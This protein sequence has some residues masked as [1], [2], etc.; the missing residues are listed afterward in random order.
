MNK[1][2]DSYRNAYQLLNIFN[3][4]GSMYQNLQ[5]ERKK[6]LEV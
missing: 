4:L 5:S 2:K 1:I 6:I 3:N